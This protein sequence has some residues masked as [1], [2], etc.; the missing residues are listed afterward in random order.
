MF[1]VLNKLS[2]EVNV[3]TE[4]KDGEQKK[5]AGDQEK[6]ESNPHILSGL[7]DTRSRAR[8]TREGH[9]RRNYCAKKEPVNRKVNTEEEEPRQ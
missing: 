5:L 8:R 4:T 2:Q 1:F 9:K 3:V 7:G 6:N